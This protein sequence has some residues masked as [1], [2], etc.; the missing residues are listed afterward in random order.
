[1]IKKITLLTLFFVYGL[2][3]FSQRTGEIAIYTN[4]GYP[5]HVVLNGV[6]QNSKAET[7][8]KVQGLTNSWYGCKLMGDDNGFS[9][10]KNLMVKMD[11]LITYRLISK[12]G[13]MKLRF[14]SETPL[15]SAPSDAS[16]SVIVFHATET[17]EVEETS[18]NTV[19]TTRTSTEITES[20][21][22]ESLEMGSSVESGSE[23]LEMTSGIGTSEENVN[24]SVS[25]NE[26]GMN[27]NMSVIGEGTED[28]NS[29]TPIETTGTESHTSYE[30]TTTITSSSNISSSGTTLEETRSIEESTFNEGN[31]FATD[32]LMD[33]SSFDSAKSQIKNESFPDDQE[34]VAKQMGTSKCLSVEQI[35]EIASILSFSD[36]QLNFIK[37]AHSNCVDQDN[38]YQ[39]MEVFDFS[40]DKEALEKFLQEQ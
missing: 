35:K 2:T 7:N 19:I 32:C 24:I 20:G 12:K 16:Q 15:K 26:N 39:L 28:F 11:T 8:V 17:P 33:Q 3:A 10:E 14:F 30:K 34:R 4:E 37:S 18:S 21:S 5:F 31:S 27:V 25:A 22:S 40:S 38:Y 9:V 29:N 23:G 6:V 13:K 1:M 36:N